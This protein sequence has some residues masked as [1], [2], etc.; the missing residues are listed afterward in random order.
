MTTVFD[1]SQQIQQWYPVA[2]AEGWDAI[3]LVAGR[4]ESTVESILVTVDVTEST[5]REARE[6]G[7]NLILA[8]HP[9]LFGGVTS[10]GA[11]G[12]KGRIVHD[13]IE[14]NI[15]LLVAH[16]N[17][18]SGLEGVSDALAAVLGVR[19]LLPLEPKSVEPL[20][21]FV[22]FVPEAEAKAV[23]D[24]MASAGAGRI[25]N[26]ERCAFQL[27][28]EGTF[29]PLP[30]AQPH[31]GSVGQ[32]ERVIEVRIEM[33]AARNLRGKVISA[34]RSAHPYE[35]PAFD[36]IALAEIP[37]RLGLGRVG[38]LTSATT[39]ADFAEVVARQLPS[40]HH[41]VRV[42]GDLTRPVRRVAVCGGSG[43]SLLAAANAAGADVYVTS[44]LK[45]HAV[46]DHL[47]EG[48][49]AVIDVA[50]YAS[51]FPWCEHV[52]NRLASTYAASDDNV[53]VH[54]STSVTDP[55]SHHLR[56]QS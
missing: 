8:H 46:S 20:D 15:A 27:S 44:D 37:D 22:V 35:E 50:H 16:T 30:G 41:G 5:V 51:E 10:V 33:V 3:G 17:A 42:A 11:V 53:S 13:L 43:D 14:N 39:L 1:V 18:D 34:M 28:G 21:K 12:T 47:A 38:D 32:V 52:A 31:V 29:R 25:G 48:G 55:W 4:P 45:H 7:A 26:Y 6:R 36:V 19:D 2:L 24:A 40:T 54:V 56:S 49:C 23:V 9:L